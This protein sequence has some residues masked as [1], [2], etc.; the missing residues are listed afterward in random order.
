[1][2][3]R[4][5]IH[6]APSGATEAW[7]ALPRRVDDF[8]LSEIEVGSFPGATWVVGNA[9]GILA[10]GAVGHSVLK[11]AKIRVAPET[12]FDVASLTKPLITAALVLQAY[13]A[14]IIELTE[15]VSRYLPELAK[16]DKK[17]LTF[18]DLLTHRGGFQAWYPL[19]VEGFGDEA[20]LQAILRRP[21]RYRPGTREIYSCLGFVLLHQAI[22]RIHG[23]TVEDL[24]REQLFAPVSA[25]DSIFH[26]S[27]VLKYRVAATEWGNANERQMVARRG[28]PFD[29]FR[30]YMIW[31][32][33]NDG[34]AYYMG[35][36]AGNAGLFSTSRDVYRMA[37]AWIDGSHRLL[38]EEVIRLSLRNYTIGMAENRGLGWQLQTGRADHPSSV[39]SRSTFGHTGFTGTSLYVDP[40]RDLILVL[41][42]NRLHPSCKPLNTQYIR[43]RFHEIVLEEL[44]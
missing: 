1:M 41:L 42:T 37:A 17:T 4:L 27:E 29:R 11:P 34:N 12:I 10:E 44:S 9:A 6:S 8:L 3:N 40:E 33:V 23:R 30:D 24:S 35:G 43:K 38:P 18:L 14:S 16:S 15:P 13:A 25:S 39:L 2:T 31:G 26:P 5:I 21:L 32:E 28:L 20:Y 19:Y 22:E 7:P 36:V